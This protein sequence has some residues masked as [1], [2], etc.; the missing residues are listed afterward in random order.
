[1]HHLEE[2]E[3]V[4]EG[5]EKELSATRVQNEMLVRKTVAMNEQLEKISPLADLC[6]KQAKE[7]TALESK[8]S[9]QDEEIRNSAKHIEELEDVLMNMEADNKNLQARVD[10]AAASESELQA[11]WEDATLLRSELSARDALI[12]HYEETIAECE[13]KLTLFGKIFDVCHNQG[14]GL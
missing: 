10:A 7:I 9:L 14:R 11:S 3:E 4:V 2:L 5:L 6:E 13:R 1:M 12:Q 8:C